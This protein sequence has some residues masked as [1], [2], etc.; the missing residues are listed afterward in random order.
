M[1]LKL[2]PTCGKNATALIYDDSHRMCKTC[3]TV[4]Q[5]GLWNNRP[6]EDE[7]QSDFDY[8]NTAFFDLYH[9]H[10]DAENRADRLAV[11]ADALAARIEELE[12]KEVVF[13]G[14]ESYTLKEMET[15]WERF[16]RLK[17]EDKKCTLANDAEE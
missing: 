10:I 8:I 14:E 13:D 15:I 3:G 11:V 16:T 1:E 12:Q 7:L 17:S 6:I 4:I 2:C 9:E 5:A